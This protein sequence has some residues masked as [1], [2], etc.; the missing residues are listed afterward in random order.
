MC[1]NE[2]PSPGAHVRPAWI[3]SPGW[4]ERNLPWAQPPALW[5]QPLRSHP[6]PF[7]TRHNRV[8]FPNCARTIV[9]LE[10]P[11]LPRLPG[12]LL[13]I[14]QEPL[15][16]LPP[17]PG[18]ADHT[19]SDTLWHGHTHCEAHK[20]LPSQTMAL[21]PAGAHRA[22]TRE[23]PPLR[24]QTRALTAVVGLLIVKSSVQTLMPAGW[25]DGPTDGWMG[26]WVD[27]EKGRRNGWM[28]G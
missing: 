21:H 11:P 3:L 13:H 8:D 16:G 26:R 15:Q 22:A 19:P 4:P 27:E 2:S 9:L 18:R 7:Q 25:M 12:Q 28:A 5:P 14:P 23:P 24:N 6:L 20:D 17:L 1:V 10:S